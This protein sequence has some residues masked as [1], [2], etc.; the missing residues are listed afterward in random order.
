MTA[1]VLE[2]TI[3][4]QDDKAT[5]EREKQPMVPLASEAATLDSGIEAREKPGI[6]V[7]RYTRS[8]LAI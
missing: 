6:K 8:D 7:L 4:G 5:V 2:E 3:K 1:A